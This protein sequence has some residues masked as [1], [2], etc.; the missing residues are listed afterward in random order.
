MRHK[1]H[2]EAAR[3]SR[4]LVR[5]HSLQLIAE[6]SDWLKRGENEHTLRVV[7]VQDELSSAPIVQCKGI[8][9]S[10]RR[11]K[12]TSRGNFPVGQALRE[13]GDYCAHHLCQAPPA[14]P[15]A[16][17]VASQPT[18]EITTHFMSRKRACPCD[19]RKVVKFNFN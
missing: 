5:E 10:G 11:C 18:P 9:L 4:D 15:P 2:K 19:E 7:L 1:L 12:N 17:R 14:T 3:L 6:S 16:Q 8:V 13:G